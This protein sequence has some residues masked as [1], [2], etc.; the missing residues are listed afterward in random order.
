MIN[1]SVMRWLV[2]LLILK[3]FVSFAME[4]E[5]FEQRTEMGHLMPL[6]EIWVLDRLC[7]NT[8]YQAEVGQSRMKCIR[9]ARADL[10]HCTNEY[11]RKIPRNDSREIDGRLRYRDFMAG[12]TRCL[13]E[14]IRRRNLSEVREQ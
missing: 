1:P 7:S 10:P 5:G 6:Y 9:R 11:R 8:R 4:N 14:Q 3:S 13:K 2:S 12:Y